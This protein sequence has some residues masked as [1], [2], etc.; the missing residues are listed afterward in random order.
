MYL[1]TLGPVKLPISL[2]F[3]RTTTTLL[4][5]MYVVIPSYGWI[6]LSPQSFHDCIGCFVLAFPS[7]F[8][9]I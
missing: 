3:K 5:H 7:K 2:P 4:Q 9:P 6:C 1:T 8:K